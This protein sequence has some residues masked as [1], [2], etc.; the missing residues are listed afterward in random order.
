MSK[1]RCRGTVN[2]VTLPTSPPCSS[3]RPAPEHAERRL[4]V[5]ERP[6]EVRDRASLN[7]LE[8]LALDAN[9]FA[10]SSVLPT[11]VPISIADGKGTVS[12]P[13]R[14]APL[15]TWV[16]S[17]ALRAPGRLARLLEAPRR[18]PAN[19]LWTTWTN[20]DIKRGIPF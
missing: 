10:S 5:G 2:P 15:S 3:L 12:S 4:E 6:L 13:S 7:H 9:S 19:E 18:R 14:Q 16:H 1:L 11:A 17:R 20:R 8:R